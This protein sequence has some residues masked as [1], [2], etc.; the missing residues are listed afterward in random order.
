MV[1]AMLPPPEM[2]DHEPPVGVP[3]R[4]LVCV[5]HIV[6]VLVVLLA[7]PGSALTVKVLSLVVA[8]QPPLAGMVYLIVTLV[9][10]V[11]LAGV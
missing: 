11:M 3:V 10:E 5:S 9:L 2:M 7:V 8:A 1:P 6:A 4:L